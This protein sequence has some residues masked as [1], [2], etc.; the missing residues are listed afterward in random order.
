MSLFNLFMGTNPFAG[1]LMRMAGVPKPRDIARLRDCYLDK[2][3]YIVVLTRTGGGNRPDYE[4]SN[5]AL[6]AV[7]GFVD[8]LDWDQDSTY[9]LWRYHVPEKYAGLAAALCK[10]GAQYD[11][12]EKFHNSLKSMRPPEP[13][14]QETVQATLAE[15]IPDLQELLAET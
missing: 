14:Q 15:F 5:A 1:V 6:T 2:Q 12:T 10:C 7:P 11:L 13:P 4:E 8:G 9:A 3:G